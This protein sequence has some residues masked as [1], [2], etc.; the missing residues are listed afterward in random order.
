MSMLCVTPAYADCDNFFS[1]KWWETASTIDVEANLSIGCRLSDRRNNNSGLDQ[2][3]MYANFKTFKRIFEKNIATPVMPWDLANSATYLIMR[4]ANYENSE[5]TLKVMEYLLQSGEN[6]NARDSSGRTAIMVAALHGNLP[7]VEFLLN[8][9]A[10]INNRDTNG[11]SLLY[12][13]TYDDLI[14]DKLIQAGADIN[15]RD[16]SGSTP[17]HQISYSGTPKMVKLLIEA[18]A[19]LNAKD[20]YGKT[21]LH[22]AV[23]CWVCN[24]GRISILVKAGIDIFAKNTDGKTAWETV[25]DDD[26]ILTNSDYWVLNDMMYNLKN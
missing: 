9:G 7:G 15:S 14:L 17:L 8:N 23:E 19:D 20:K 26:R 22:T 5:E 11:S 2:F 4:A 13:P 6:I 10:D 21:A 12:F 16:F 18:G 25:E 24:E 1:P 3:A